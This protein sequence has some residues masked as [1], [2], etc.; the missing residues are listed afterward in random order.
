MEGG[1]GVLLCTL[2]YSILLGGQS[3]SEGNYA[4]SE[5][6]NVVAH[7]RVYKYSRC[8]RIVWS[9]ILGEYIHCGLC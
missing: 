7:G 9:V 2:W 1:G 8:I 4:P 6:I 3:E 5:L